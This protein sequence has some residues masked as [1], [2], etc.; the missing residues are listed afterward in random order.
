MLLF[1]TASVGVETHIFVHVLLMMQALPQLE[2]DQASGTRHHSTEDT[3][4]G[5]V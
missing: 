1:G 4:T 5:I 2:T 3:L